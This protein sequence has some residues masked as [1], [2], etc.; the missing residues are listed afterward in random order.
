MC[1]SSCLV[2]A[3]EAKKLS[4]NVKRRAAHGSNE[5]MRIK[6]RILESNQRLQCVKCS[7]AQ[8]GG[9]DFWHRWTKKFQITI[10][11]WIGRPKQ[12]PEIVKTALQSLWW[13][14]G[15]RPA[16]IAELPRSK[17]DQELFPH[18]AYVEIFVTFATKVPYLTFCDK[19]RQFLM[20]EMDRERG[21]YEKI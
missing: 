9:R 21:N 2:T 18:S 20:Q 14:A 1:V 6:A 8:D 16:R 5:S 17:F 15:N 12:L 7:R 3:N 11:T 10:K 4:S 13:A 19:M